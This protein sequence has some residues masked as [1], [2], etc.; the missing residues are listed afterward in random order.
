MCEF[1]KSKSSSCTATACTRLHTKQENKSQNTVCQIT[2]R[3][4]CTCV[5]VSKHIGRVAR[6]IHVKKSHNARSDRLWE[7]TAPWFTLLNC[8]TNRVLKAYSMLYQN[9]KNVGQFKRQTF[10]T[11]TLVKE[12]QEINPENMLITQ[13]LNDRSSCSANQRINAI[14]YLITR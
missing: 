6:G 2:S 3:A 5:R 7:C 10:N 1:V 11:T 9:L 13:Y 8:C 12:D 4:D 14:G